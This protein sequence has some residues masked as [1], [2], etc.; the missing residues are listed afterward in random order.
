MFWV[1][2]W[3]EDRLNSSLYGSSNYCEELGGFVTDI[4]GMD[5]YYCF[6]W[7]GRLF[8][9]LDFLFYLVDTVP[10]SVCESMFEAV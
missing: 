6:G 9:F 2:Y 4:L 8:L 1:D 3:D 5:Y 10:S 7:R